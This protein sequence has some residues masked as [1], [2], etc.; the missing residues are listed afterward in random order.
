MP[1]FLELINQLGLHHVPVLDMAFQLPA[2]IDML[3]TMAEGSSVLS[4]A[5]RKA[6]REG[7]VIRLRIDVYPLRLYPINFC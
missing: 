5:H 1:D 4:P 6:E 7:L 2:T 3:L